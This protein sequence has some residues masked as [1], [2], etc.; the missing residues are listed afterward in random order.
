MMNLKPSWKFQLSILSLIFTCSFSFGQNLIDKHATE[1]TLALYHNL[2]K[3]SSQ[4]FLFGHQDD[5]AY[6]VGWRKDQNRSDVKEVSGSYPAVHGWDVGKSLSN[7][8]NIDSVNFDDM[9]NWIR[10]I[11]ERGG[12]N[13]ISWHL[14]NP[15]TKGDSWDKTPAVKEIL[16]GGSAHDEFV[17]ELDHLSAFLSKCKS[18]KTSIPIIFRPWHE[19]NGDW[20]WWGKGNCTE[21]EY[22]QLWHFTVDY[23][24]NTKQHHNLIY[25]WSPDR[26]RTDLSDFN[27]SYLYGYPGDNY[28]DILGLD[29]Y[30]DVGATWNKKSVEEQ[31]ADFA[32]SLKGVVTLAAEKNKIT[33]MTETGMEGI[34]NPTWYTNVIL[35][36]IVKNDIKIAYLLVW[37]NANT[38]HHYAPYKGHPGEKNF[39]I[40]YN[41]KRTLFER[42]IQNMYISNKPLI[43]K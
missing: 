25:A 8:M 43:R 31:Q 32:T 20:F 18:G 36:P 29:N 9:L 38:T 1:E 22:I 27:T 13:T 19:H 24:K 37:R 35:D 23:L 11:Y 28:V 26:S 17:K 5:D 6:G 10:K 34:K 12:I 2:K 7:P 39:M 21:D 40:F 41:D 33:A 42:D 4:G 16:P 14:D 30:M 3:I 15:V